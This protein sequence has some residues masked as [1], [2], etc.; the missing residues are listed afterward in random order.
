MV[1]VDVGVT[2]ALSPRHPTKKR[3]RSKLAFPGTKALKQNPEALQIGCK[4]R[5]WR[6][7]LVLVHFRRRLE[8]MR[9]RERYPKSHPLK[10]RAGQDSAGW[11]YILFAQR[12]T[13]GIAQMT[14]HLMSGHGSPTGLTV[15]THLG[16]S[17][18]HFFLVAKTEE[19]LH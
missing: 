1:H 6:A 15:W 19:S 16:D 14:N 18:K 8:T 11:T 7:T 12:T 13:K 5:R 4:L 3:V 2:H 9:P 17:V 10:K